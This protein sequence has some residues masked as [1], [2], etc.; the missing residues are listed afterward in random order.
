MELKSIK[1]VR[2]AVLPVIVLA[3]KP[4]CLTGN[5]ISLARYLFDALGTIIF[6]LGIAIFFWQ[7]LTLISLCIN[8]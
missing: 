3:A 4:G 5:N 6:P 8:D 2:R 7:K 1:T